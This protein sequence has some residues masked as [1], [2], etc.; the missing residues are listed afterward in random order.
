M[1][2]IAITQPIAKEITMQNVI[3]IGRVLVPVEQIAYVE[4]FEPPADG[5]IKPD[6]PYNSRIVLLNRETVLC[7]ATPPEFAD[8]NGFRLLPR[9][10]VATTHAIDVR[11]GSS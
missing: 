3:T 1:S 6:K 5:R 2:W 10:N 8:A 7:E 11:R 9:D 4:A